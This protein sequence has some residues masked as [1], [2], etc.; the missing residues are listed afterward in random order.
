MGDPAVNDMRKPREAYTRALKEYMAAMEATR[1]ASLKNTPGAFFGALG[2]EH[3]AERTFD[4]AREV[5]FG[6]AC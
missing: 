4:E 1:L 5:Y 2:L 6:L 3:E